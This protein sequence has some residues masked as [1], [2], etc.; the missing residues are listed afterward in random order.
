MRPL[1]LLH[2]T[3][4]ALKQCASGKF[5]LPA[6]TRIIHRTGV[7]R[8]A[9]FVCQKLPGILLFLDYP[10]SGDEPLIKKLDGDVVSGSP[11][12]DRC[13]EHPPVH[14]IATAG[15]HNRVHTRQRTEHGFD[16]SQPRFPPV[17]RSR[18]TIRPG[19]RNESASDLSG[20]RASVWPGSNTGAVLPSYAE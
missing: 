6:Y 2:Y 13:N 3:R 20:A 10:G 11:V 9:A 17:E 12:R 18:K 5:S 19:T 14:L 8:R 15:V 16:S 4:T 1:L 7:R